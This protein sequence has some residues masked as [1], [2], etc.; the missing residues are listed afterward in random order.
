MLHEASK[1]FDQ[2]MEIYEDQLKAN[3]ANLFALKRKVSVYKA[4]GYFYYKLC[5]F[6]FN[7][8]VILIFRGFG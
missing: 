8:Y 5:I 2:A 4:K 3:P 1:E 6:R 7:S